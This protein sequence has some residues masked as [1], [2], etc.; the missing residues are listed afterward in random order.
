MENYKQLH[1]VKVEILPLKH[2]ICWQSKL[3]TAAEVLVF[4][5]CAAYSVILIDCFVSPWMLTVSIEFTKRWVLPGLWICKS[6]STRLGKAGF[7]LKV[8]SNCDCLI[9]HLD[10][11]RVL[12]S[13]IS[14]TIWKMPCCLLF[15]MY[16]IH[17]TWWC[18]YLGWLQKKVK[19]LHIRPF[20]TLAFLWV[21]TCFLLRQKQ[22]KPY[23]NFKYTPENHFR[24]KQLHF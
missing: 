8:C 24:I 5:S 11:G 17:L 12:N 13:F 23:W 6:F 1:L 4:Q 9:L 16:G 22:I 18:M 10:V 21:Y 2:N 15:R 19:H 7:Y 3:C 20:F 14:I